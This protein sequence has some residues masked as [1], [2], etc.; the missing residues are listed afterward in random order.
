MFFANNFVNTN[1]FAFLT[2]SYGA[3]VEGAGAEI[4]Y[5][6]L[7]KFYVLSS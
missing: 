2:F 7:N 6:Q 3:H 5:D 1:C 4:L